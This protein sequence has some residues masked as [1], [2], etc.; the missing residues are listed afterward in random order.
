MTFQN[1]H[2]DPV[3]NR[4]NYTSCRPVG[5][6]LVCPIS[7]WEKRRGSRDRLVITQRNYHFVLLLV[8]L[9][10]YGAVA[11]RGEPTCIVLLIHPQS[12]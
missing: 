10:L 12:I 7:Q 6:Q 3:M 4:T 1:I 11:K 9:I 2:H 5:E 8:N